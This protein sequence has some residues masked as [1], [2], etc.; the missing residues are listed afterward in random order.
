M[1]RTTHDATVHSGERFGVEKAANCR[2]IVER[3]LA[4]FELRIHPDL[5]N[6]DL[7]HSLPFDLATW[8]VRMS[9]RILSHFAETGDER[10]RGRRIMERLFTSLEIWEKYKEAS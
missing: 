9:I 1:S 5:K 2:V 10:E 7:D 8:T 4:H 6:I 3:H